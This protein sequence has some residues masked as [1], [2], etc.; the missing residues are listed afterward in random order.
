[1]S[2]NKPITVRSLIES[3]GGATEASA[4]FGVSYH[5]VYKWLQSGNLP[6]TEFTGETKYSEIFAAHPN[7]N[8]TAD[9]ILAAMKQ[10]RNKG[11]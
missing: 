5:A 8:H 10:A 7:V 2:K 3:V 6:R 11:A 9:E 1:M 4:M